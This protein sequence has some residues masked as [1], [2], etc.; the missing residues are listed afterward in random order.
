M[1]TAAFVAAKLTLPLYVVER[2]M[3]PN[4]YVVDESVPFTAPGS[5]FR[6]LWDQF[7]RVEDWDRQDF[8]R[9]TE[10]RWR[11]YIAR[12]RKDGESKDSGYQ[13]VSGVLVGQCLFDHNCLGAP[14]AS[15]VEFVEYI[16]GEKPEVLDKDLL[17]YR[18]HPLSPE[19]YP[20]GTIDTQYGPIRV[21]LSDPWDTLRTGPVLY[22]WNS[23]LG[24][25]GILVFGSTVNILDPQCHYSWIQQSNNN[26]KR[27]YTVFLNEV[28][29]LPGDTNS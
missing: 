19:E 16:L 24:L 4:S 10:S 8:I 1:N 29:I 18:P 15:A 9:L 23:T 22:T 12:L 13:R 26:E 17:V 14:F 3:L 25:E 6:S 5:R 2:G 7:R 21:D 20:H 27:M 11:L 28:S